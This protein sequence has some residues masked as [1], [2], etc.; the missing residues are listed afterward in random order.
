LELVLIDE[1]GAAFLWPKLVLFPVLLGVL[2][3]RLTD[4]EDLKKE[5]DLRLADK[6]AR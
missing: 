5:K 4:D 1:F 6:T 3:P 2:T